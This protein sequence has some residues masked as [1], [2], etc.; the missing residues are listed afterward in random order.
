MRRILPSSL[1]AVAILVVGLP[2]AADDKASEVGSPAFEIFFVHAI[3]ADL[4]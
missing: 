2:L 3:V 4:G 1:V